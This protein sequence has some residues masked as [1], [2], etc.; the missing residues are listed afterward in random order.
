MKK[1]I[2]LFTLSLLIFTSCSTGKKALQKG[3]Y[4][5]ALTKAVERLKSAPNNKNAT[6]VLLDGYPM[7][8]EWLEQELELVQKTA[9]QFRWESAIG[10][11]EQSNRLSE[12]I[13]TTPAAW[14][15]ISNPVSYTK[16]LDAAY[17]EAANDRYN[18]GMLEFEVNTR[19]SARTAY[20]HFRTANNYIPDYKNV[21]ELIEIAKDKATIK[22][23][24]E[25]IPVY[26]SKY[27]L[28][29]EFF[30]N[31]VFSYLNNK[32]DYNS[33][34]NFYTSYQ[35]E[36]E[37][38]NYPD[39]I[40]DM[41]FFDFSVGNLSRNQKEESLGKR[42][43]IKSSD[44][45]NIQYK[46]YEAKLK[47]FTDQ[48]ISGGTLR[49]RIIEPAT[50]KIRIDAL[51]P[52]SFTWVNEYAMFIGDKEALDN[53]QLKLINGNVLPLPAEQDLFFE[54]TKPI[55]TQLTHRLNRFFNRY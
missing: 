25:T 26:S 30:Y 37:N 42:V 8:I 54:F 38:I 34:V 31:Q 5:S 29:A 18:A 24:L 7:A 3:N 32:Y 33:F 22:V 49:M 14:K 51:I 1:L 47:T 16:K 48:V 2:L 36:Q 23:I 19:L 41:E 21:I 45:T 44:T 20:N 9:V 11:M 46:T 53:D 13:R 35:A 4:F 55:F 50:D 17:L 6:T 28:S 10:L 52:G 43:K 40:V 15:I 12:K 39:F 27:Q